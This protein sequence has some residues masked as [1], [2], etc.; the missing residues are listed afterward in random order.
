MLTFI[1]RF[2]VSLL[3]AASSW[4]GAGTAQARA[5]L[6][7]PSV[8]AWSSL[9]LPSTTTWTNLLYAEGRWVAIGSGSVFASS[10]NGSQWTTR[11]V[12]T[13]DW[14]SIAFGNGH[15]VV[16]SGDDASNNPTELLSSN[17]VDWRAAP[18]PG[19]SWSS[20]TFGLGR[21]VGV[22]AQG[23]LMTSTT[24]RNWTVTWHAISFNFTSVAFG[25]GEFMAVDQLHG[26]ALL[27]FNG[28]VWS[29]CPIASLGEAWLRITYG[30]GD[31]LASDAAGVVATTMRGYF[32]AR[33]PP[34]PSSA[35]TFGCNTFLSVDGQRASVAPYGGP[36]RSVGS[37]PGPLVTWVSAAY[38]DGHFAVL[39][40]T[41]SFDQAAVTGSC[42]ETLPTPPQQVSGNVESGQVWTYQHPP[43]Q[44]GSS[45]VA[46]YLVTITDG[47]TSAHCAA[48]VYYEPNCI[49]KGL[50]NHE[51]YYVSTQVRN[52]LGFSAP[53]DPQFVIPVPVGALA[54]RGQVVQGALVLQVT[55]IAANAL[56]FYPVTTVYVHVG[57]S[58]DTCRPSPF[59]QCLLTLPLPSAGRQ[60]LYATYVGYGH[61]YTSATSF[62]SIP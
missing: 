36:W 17:G 41:G 4:I 20:L 11:T 50:V 6:P 60:A 24:G 9:A 29:F 47:H 22:S 48:P 38:G 35:Q 12:P 40:D 1:L 8:H 59:G 28:L 10:V 55:G 31:F 3:L 18:G 62:V 42:R 13:G 51:V 46:S 56:G 26:D 23:Q 37:L 61:S 44:P 5:A 30:N 57:S 53:T 34:H 25:D 15:F 2:G 32:W 19:G 7:T 49:I 52:S 39:S 54:V 21:F 14:R 45:P 33:H 16:L 27:S 58:V 43:A